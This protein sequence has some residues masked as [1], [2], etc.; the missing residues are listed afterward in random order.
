MTSND[1][2][3]PEE[4]WKEMIEEFGDSH[5][6]LGPKL[7]EF[8]HSDSYNLMWYV[9]WFKFAGKMIGDKG[10]A[11]VFDPL[12][13]L[14]SWT[15]ACE[16]NDVVGVLAADDSY[17]EICKAWPCEKLIFKKNEAVP[18][19]GEHEFGGVVYY[20]V[21][22]K[23]TTSEWNSFFEDASHML[24]DGGVVIAGG[25]SEDLSLILKEAA[26]GY[27][28]TVFMFGQ[29]QPHPCISPFNAVI[30]MAC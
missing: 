15:V 5:G 4:S 19:M 18:N 23:K 11:L 8:F 20:D 30:V 24:K 16:T 13:G 17:E 9:S 14:G 25:R 6:S 3:N 26:S 10:K 7:S 22:H 27:F 2:V 21:G 1:T 29:G 28:K 12:E